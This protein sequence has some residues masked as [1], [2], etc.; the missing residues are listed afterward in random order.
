MKE[1]SYWIDTVNKT[2]Q[3][4]SITSNIETDI[5]II[6]A[7]MTGLSCAYHLTKYNKQVTVVEADTIGYGASGRSTGKL[8]AQH[9]PIYHM[10]IESIG[11]QQTKLHYQA[12]KQSLFEIETICKKHSIPIFNSDTMLYA[13]TLQGKQCLQDEYQ[14]YIDL[15]IPCSFIDHVSHIPNCIA[16]LKMHGQATFHPYHFLQE[17]SS[18][19]TKQQGVIYENSHVSQVLKQPDQTYAVTCNG[20]TI[21]ANTVICATQVP[22]ID[23]GHL[24]VTKMQCEQE[25]IYAISNMMMPVCLQIDDQKYSFHTYEKTLLFVHNNHKSGIPYSSKT[26]PGYL[27]LKAYTH[28]WSSSDYTTIDKL[29]FIGPIDKNNHHLLFA[30]GYGKWGNTNGYFAGKLLCDYVMQQHSPY[31][32]LYSPFRKLPYLSSAYLKENIQNMTNFLKG[33]LYFFDEELPQPL[34][35]KKIRKNHHTYGAYREED[36]T[37]YIVDI[38]CPHLGCICNFNEIDKTWDCPCHGSR[39]SYKGDVVKGPTT[40]KLNTY[41]QSCNHIDPHIFEKR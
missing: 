1:A 17:L 2:Y 6:G 15:Q 36:G 26:M 19:I 11:L 9:G 38:T 8:T 3:Y 25:H 32:S 23:H 31:H 20:Y 21:K 28:H 18:I 24:Y 37:L 27:D 14:A 30:S 40:S 29:P 22:I 39:Y 12:Q 10:L 34:Q 33:H 13:T 4:A 16:A 7:G 35:G 41:T 5:L